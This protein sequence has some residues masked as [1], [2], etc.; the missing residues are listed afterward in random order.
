MSYR[1]FTTL[2][3]I[4]FS[5]LLHA[6]GIQ[7]QGRVLHEDEPLAKANVVEL[8]ANHRIVNQTLTDE[9][10]FFTL[11]VSGGKTSLRVTYQGMKKFTKKIGT[12]TNWE[13]ELKKEESNNGKV[14]SRHETTK[15][16]V[17]HLNGRVIPQLTW[18]EHLTDTTFCIIVPVRVYNAVEEYPMGRKMSIQNYNG[19]IVAIGH[20]IE[21]AVPE[22]GTPQ[23][24]DPYV[25]TSTNNSADN[26]SQLTTNDRD[27][28]AYPRF[29]FT[30]TEL[31]YLIDHT[32]ELACFAV[33]TSRG[34]NF[35]L[36]YKSKY[37]SKELQKILNK[38][39]K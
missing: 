32:S 9:A 35:W 1:I 6:Q 29:V 13:I 3:S 31:E 19:H 39:L 37:F 12:Q 34:D 4:T 25:R 16:L 5:V 23:S 26:N 11:N 33:D 24:Y 27:Y 22:E 2:L 38:M 21:P 36:Y 28:F 10:G 14:K 15:L 20:C 8:D 18:I 30:K 7:I 17:G